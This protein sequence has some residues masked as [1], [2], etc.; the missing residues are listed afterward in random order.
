MVANKKQK[1]GASIKQLLKKN[2]LWFIPV[3]NVDGYDY[4]F[5]DKGS[6]LWRKNLRDN[7]GG[8]FSQATDGVDTNRNFPTS[9]TTTRKAPRRTRPPRPTAPTPAPSPRCTP[10]AALMTLQGQVRHRLP[11]VRPADPLPRGLAGGDARLRLAA[12]GGDRGR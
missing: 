3:V 6:R 10:C 7:D 4:T 11:L 9:G 1:G 12:D 5:V 2:E 8:G